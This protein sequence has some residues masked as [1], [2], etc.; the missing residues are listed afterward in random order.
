MNTQAQNAVNTMSV[1]QIMETYCPFGDAAPGVTVDQNWEAEIT[2]VT[3]E[4]GSIVELCG[5]SAVA[6]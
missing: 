4:D 3:F 2:A 1:T 5:S 6:K